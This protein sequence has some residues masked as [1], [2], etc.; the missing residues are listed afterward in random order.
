MRDFL[1]DSLY[2]GIGLTLIA[3]EIGLWMKRRFKLA[4]F[5][6]LLVAGA[7]V[8]GVLLL[9]GVSYEEYNSSANYITYL[10]TPTT[11]CLAVPLYSQIEQLKA[12]KFAVLG[13][14][15]AGVLT[16]LLTIFGLSLLFGLPKTEYVTLLPKS[17]TTAIAMPLCE[18]YGGVVPITI[19][20]VT[21]T[22][23]LGS[24]IASGVCRLFRISEPVA[25]GL[26]IGTASHAAGTSRAIELGETQGAM[27]SLAIAVAGILTV[28][29]VPFFVNLY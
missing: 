28:V 20:A 12:H 15:L 7:I 29:V 27:S 17:I 2:F 13:G 9:T 19:A 26:A 10:L 8:I 1:A 18:V 24:V 16:N 22:G 6:P 11:V 23:I 21:I 14:I 25:Q 3:Y 4:I 5:H